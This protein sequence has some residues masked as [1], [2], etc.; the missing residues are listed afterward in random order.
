MEVNILLNSLKLSDK[1]SPSDKIKKK[2]K[3]IILIIIKNKMLKHLLLI[4]ITKPSD[5]KRKSKTS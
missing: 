3:S 5:F 4:K 2:I 1:P